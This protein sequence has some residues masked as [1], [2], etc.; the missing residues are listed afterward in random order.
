MFDKNRHLLKL[1][2]TKVRRMAALIHKTDLNKIVMEKT[3]IN[4]DQLKKLEQLS[5]AGVSANGSYETDF[6]VPI[7]NG[8]GTYSLS[9]T[10]WWV[11]INSVVVIQ[12]PAEGSWHIIVRDGSKEIFNRDGITK[13]QP[14][15]FNY[16]TGFSVDLNITFIWSEGKDTTLNGHVKVSY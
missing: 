7:K 15:S 8:T 6:S 12:S 14:V 16:S 11:K 1:I 5:K 13:G 9:K 3:G 2:K 10:T 4:E